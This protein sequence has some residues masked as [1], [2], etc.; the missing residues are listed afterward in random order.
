M[1]AV[2]S[3]AAPHSDW[4]PSRS[5]TSTR[6]DLSH[7][8]PPRAK[9]TNGPERGGSPA[10]AP[11]PVARGEPAREVPGVHAPG[12]ELRVGEQRALQPQVR[13]DPLDGAP[14]QRAAQR[15]ERPVTVAAARDDLG[16]QRVVVRR[17]AGARLDMGVDPR[18]GTGRR[19]ERREHGAGDR[20]RARPEVAG[21]V[22]GVDPHS[23]AC[24]ASV[25]SSCFSRSGRPSA[26]AICSA[27]RSSPVIASVTGCSTWIRAF[28][29]R[30]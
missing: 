29:S 26:M 5:D 16:E 19:R 24:P 20:A 2:R 15:R 8:D 9:I 30:K 4:L 14:V 11:C 7:R 18:T 12:R 13:G 17:H 25:T 28:T 10:P 3:P 23:I 27:T 1:C 21:R 22:L 6:P